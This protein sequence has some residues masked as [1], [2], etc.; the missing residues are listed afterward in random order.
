WETIG[1]DKARSATRHKYGENS[2]RQGISHLPFAQRAFNAPDRKC[3]ANLPADSKGQ[4]KHLCIHTAG[5]RMVIPNLCVELCM[6][7]AQTV[8]K[9]R[10]YVPAECVRA[11]RRQLN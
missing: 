10:A 11:S 7:L 9:P 3:V 5:I 4:R 6:R 2:P 1:R 8:C